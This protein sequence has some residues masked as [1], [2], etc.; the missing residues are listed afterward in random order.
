MLCVWISVLVVFVYDLWKY[1]RGKTGYWGTLCVRYWCYLSVMSYYLCF[2]A[3]ALNIRTLH[4]YV[5]VNL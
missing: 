2:I 1:I 5:T 4:V 3:T